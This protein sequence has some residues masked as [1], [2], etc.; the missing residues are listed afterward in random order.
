MILKLVL[1][2]QAS[3]QDEFFDD[4]REKGFIF[5]YFD[6]D[7]DIVERMLNMKFD[8]CE[9]LGEKEASYQR[10][11][12]PRE[13]ENEFRN[14]LKKDHGLY[15]LLAPLKLSAHHF[16]PGRGMYLHDDSAIKGSYQVLFWICD[17]S[18]LRGRD[19]LFGHRHMD[20]CCVEAIKPKTGMYCILDATNKKFVHGVSELKSNSKVITLCASFLD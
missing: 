14:H 20:Y 19:F 6:L 8:L 9:D 10:K 2:Q 16:A 15:T 3:I 11:I 18:E 12:L 17:K 4:L 7:E 13:L 5:S 1:M